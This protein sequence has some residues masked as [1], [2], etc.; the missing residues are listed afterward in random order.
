VAW[1]I[2][3]VARRSAVA[4]IV[5]ILDTEEEAA[6]IAFEMRQKGQA[7]EVREWHDRGD[8]E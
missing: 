3:E 5:L 8:S 4:G 1:A 7:V 2:V 6:A